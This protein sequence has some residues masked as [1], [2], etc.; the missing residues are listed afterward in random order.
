MPDAS[1]LDT[2]ETE[3]DALHE[4]QVAIEYIYRA[5]GDLLDFHHNLGHAMDRFQNAEDA[6]RAAGHDGLADRLRDEHLPAGAVDDM[7]SYEMVADFRTNFL[8][9][10]TEVEGEVREELAD[11]VDHVAERNQQTAWRERAGRDE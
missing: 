9:D 11:G 3:R 2:T 8:A 7:W 4:S 10:I 5:Y 6:L 1:D